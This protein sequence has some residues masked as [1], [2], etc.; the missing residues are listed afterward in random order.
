[1]VVDGDGQ[2]PLRLVL[3]N[4]VVIQERIDLARRREF[5]ETDVGGLGQFFFDD[6]IAEIDALVANVNAGTGDQ[7]LD[8]LLGLATKGTLQ[9]FPTLTEFGHAV[10]P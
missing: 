1:M 10:A 5:A 9:E 7:L 8:L 2:D 3:T 6:L 4:D